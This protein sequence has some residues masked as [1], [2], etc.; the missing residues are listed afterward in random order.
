MV[1][2]QDSLTVIAWTRSDGQF[3]AASLSRLAKDGRE[4]VRGAVFNEL[5][6]ARSAMT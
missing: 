3:T 1:K 4:N 6:I 5:D 2:D